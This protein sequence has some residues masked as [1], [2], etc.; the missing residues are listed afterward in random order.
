MANLTVTMPRHMPP[1]N[2]TDL[3]VNYDE[4]SYLNMPEQR[5]LLVAH[6]V[7]MTLAFFGLLP[8]SLMLSVAR[9]PLFLA[10]HSVFL[11][12][13]GLGMAPILVYKSATPDL[14]PN[15]IHHKLGFV[16]LALLA[17]HFGAAVVRA[18]LD[19]SFEKRSGHRRV[20]SHDDRAELGASLGSTL[21]G[22]SMTSVLRTHDA[23][24]PARPS[25][26][27]GHVGSGSPNLGFSPYQDDTV[28]D[29]DSADI[30]L[31]EK[32]YGTL[33][34]RVENWLMRN[35]VFGRF[36]PLAY[37]STDVLAGCRTAAN[38]VFGV[39]NRPLVVIGFAQIVSGAITATGM[40]HGD[41][42]F[43]LLAHLIKGGVFLWLGVLTL[44]RWLGAFAEYGWAWN[45][46]PASAARNRYITCS[47][48]TVE[49]GLIFF[50]GI[51]NVFLEHLGNKDGKWSHKDLQHVSIAFMFIGGGLGGLLLESR[52]VRQL[53]NATLDQAMSARALASTYATA[54]PAHQEPATYAFSFNPFPLFTI[55]FT[56]VLMS[57]HQQATELATKIH[58]Q[59]GYLLCIAAVF[60][61]ATY[62]IYFLAPPQSYLSGRP[63]TEIL[64]S[65][66]LMAGGFIFMLSNTETVQ[67]MIY[68]GVDAMFTMNITVGLATLVMSWIIVLMALK[69]WAAQRA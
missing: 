60:R 61:F 27:S 38:V 57:Q 24:A 41:K 30:M 51:T 20:A 19:W 9:S 28:V 48:E 52:A 37:V 1:F 68:R 63:L 13:V 22:H 18:V 8:V 31:G 49:S 14:Y 12:T 26:D 35:V 56:G 6:I 55:F 65:F 33:E 25:D 50:Y 17:A 7:L 32:A 62:V 39:L 42:I 36:S 69:G 10:V 46:R 67:A 53:L 43:G 5:P 16:V 15:N 23:A 45:V 44:G 58:M 64:V 54:S 66:C 34:H 11:A 2:Y 3:F 47:M 21:A 59:W 4:T 40:G 29:D